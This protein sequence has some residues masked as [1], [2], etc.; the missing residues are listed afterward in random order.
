MKDLKRK[1]VIS[2]LLSCILL[3]GSITVTYAYS[4]SGY[5]WSS[6]T[7]KYYYDN[8]N[9]T[10]GKS[11]INTGASAWNS[12]DVT[13]TKS[14][15]YNIYCSEVSNPDASWDGITYLTYS[16]S[17]F[18]SATLYLNMSKT[19]TWNNNDAL[20]SVAVHEF[21][22]AL[23][24]SHVPNAKVIMNPYTWGTNSRY[25]TFGITTIQTDDR[26]GANALY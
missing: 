20:K 13:F 6:S 1:T 23:G 15:S 25:G 18:K 17:K 26:V 22:H 2:L 5:T 16:G 21:G 4:K 14:G 24:L 3:I 8:Y 10:R 12:T 9:S 19:N 11:Y 7:I